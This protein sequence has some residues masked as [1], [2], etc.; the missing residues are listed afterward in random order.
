MFLSLTREDTCSV[1][2][3][4]PFQH[5]THDKDRVSLCSLV[6]SSVMPGKVAG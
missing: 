6:I 2:K 3:E 1:Y 4:V 5:S